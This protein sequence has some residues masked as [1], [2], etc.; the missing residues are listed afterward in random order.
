MISPTL[1][2]QLARS[3]RTT[4][5]IWGAF[6][7]SQPV[8]AAL[9]YLVATGRATPPAPPPAALPALALAGVA[10]LAA[11]LVFAR[12]SFTDDAVRHAPAAP[13]A[14]RP[15][16]APPAGATSREQRLFAVLAHGQNRWIIAWACFES[17]GVLGLVAV[18][19]GH[20]P[21]RLLPF[22]AVAFAAIALHRPRPLALAERAD[23]LLPRD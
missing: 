7:A 12:V 11:G 15:A 20:P 16:P 5:V 9:A 6:L 13:A 22:A 17:L 1:R 2:Q 18:I 19:L 21:E 23:A 8:Y 10:A 4:F 14:T 3:A